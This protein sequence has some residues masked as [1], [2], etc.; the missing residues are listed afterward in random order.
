MRVIVKPAGLVVIGLVVLAG[1]AIPAFRGRMPG[2]LGRS[3]GSGGANLVKP[4]NWKLGLEYGAEGTLEPGIYDGASGLKVTTRTVGR[5]PWNLSV[6]LPLHTALQAGDT[7]E[8][9]F[10]ARADQ[11]R[12]IPLMLQ[13]NTPG[14]PDFWQDRAPVETSWKTFRYEAKAAPCQEWE[15]M[16]AIHAGGSVGQLEIADVVLKRK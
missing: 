1:V 12:E 2:V 14:F 4:E 9:S 16:L 10:K 5:N 15:P 11:P 3:G 6:V 8:L 13:K 7:L